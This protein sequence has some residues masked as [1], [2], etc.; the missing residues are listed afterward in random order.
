MTTNVSVSTSRFEDSNPGFR[1]TLKT[2]SSAMSAT[3]VWSAPRATI[4]PMAAS[5]WTRSP[6]DQGRTGSSL[7]AFGVLAAD[8]HCVGATAADRNDRIVYNAATG[9]LFF[10]RVGKG[11]LAGPFRDADRPLA[12]NTDFV[13]ARLTTRSFRHGRRRAQPPLVPEGS[14]MPPK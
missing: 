5:A 1:I 3:I 11:A 6:A 8:R 10:D 13:V 14:R 2:H 4:A 7:T 9:S 12:F